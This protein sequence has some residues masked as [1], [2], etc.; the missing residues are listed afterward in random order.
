MGSGERHGRAHRRAGREADGGMGRGRVQG[1]RLQRERD[2]YEAALPD[3]G[4][5]AQR[6]GSPDG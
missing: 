3:A 2:A 5:C 4:G 1:R 6:L